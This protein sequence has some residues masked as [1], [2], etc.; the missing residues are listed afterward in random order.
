[1]AETAT[2]SDDV[3]W[4]TSEDSLWMLSRLRGKAGLRKLRLFSCACCRR[5]WHLIPEPWQRVVELSERYVEGEI[6]QGEMVA[7]R[8]SLP[9]FLE[10]RAE[11][12]AWGAAAP[13]KDLRTLVFY[14]VP[15]S[16]SQATVRTRGMPSPAERTAQA[17]LLREIFGNPFR[18]VPFRAEWSAVND[19]L[20][21]RLAEAIYQERAFERMPI[22]GDALEEAGCADQRI[23]DHCRRND[24]AS[25]VGHVRGCWVLDSILGKK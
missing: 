19:G 22:L 11:R 6:R 13:G 21:L 3:A 18:P 16:A 25:G 2:V 9:R 23:L 10:D 1:M 14:D 7:A 20:V 15:V 4:L 5:I 8:P 12:A 17:H 24:S